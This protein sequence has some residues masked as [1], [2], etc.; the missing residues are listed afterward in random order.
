MTKTLLA[1]LMAA[2][3]AV[4]V[5]GAMSDEK[6]GAGVTLAEATP[7]ATIYAK[8]AEFVGKT[9]RIDG[10]VTAV[11]QEMGCWMALSTDDKGT[12][13]IRLKV[14]H[15]AGITFPIA[16]KGKN[17]SAQGVF[18]KIAADDKEGKEA[19]GEAGAKAGD[20]GAT[21]QLK[22]TGAVVK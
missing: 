8:P 10:V 15:A 4:P 14:D 20:F 7:I 1:A 17:A 5:L 16:A 13:T 18:E 21:Y 19:A 9:I 6:F 22:A 12:Q 3:V 11:C 2:V